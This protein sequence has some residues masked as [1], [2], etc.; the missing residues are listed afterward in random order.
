[1]RIIFVALLIFFTWISPVSAQ[2]NPSDYPAGGYNPIPAQYKECR[3]ELYFQSGYSAK[4][5]YW[6]FQ[7]SGFNFP[8]ARFTGI[9]EPLITQFPRPWIYTEGFV[10]ADQYFYDPYLGS[11]FPS[12]FREQTG[13]YW[14]VTPDSNGS[15]LDIFESKYSQYK[16]NPANGSQLT[17]NPPFAT[18]QY[19]VCGDLDY[20]N[21]NLTGKVIEQK[22]IGYRMSCPSDWN[23]STNPPPTL[24]QLNYPGGIDNK[25]C[26]EGFTFNK[27]LLA[28]VPIDDPDPD[29]TCQLCNIIGW[30]PHNYPAR[31]I[32]EVVSAYGQKFPFDFFSG[33]QQQ[34]NQAEPECFSY[35]GF[36]LCLIN[37]IIDAAIMILPLALFAKFIFWEKS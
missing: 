36:K 19:N 12:E 9:T 30:S 31:N 21:R 28:C 5:C 2:V 1:M 13:G 23:W 27:S 10:A 8:Y 25:V 15:S 18:A 34:G 3:T 24:D 32:S 11:G 33:F 14:K 7:S 26:D 29:P 20:Y 22:I 35:K 16:W 4:R 17:T 6:E 37:R